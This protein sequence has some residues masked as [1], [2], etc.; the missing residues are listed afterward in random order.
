M[1]ERTK[2]SFREFLVNKAYDCAV[3]EEGEA[4]ARRYLRALDDQG[5]FTDA[6]IEDILKEAFAKQKQTG[7]TTRAFWGLAPDDEFVFMTTE[8]VIAEVHAAHKAEDEED[9]FIL[10]PVVGGRHGIFASKSLHLIQGASASGKTTFA[11]QMLQAQAESRSFLE[12]TSLGPKSY[13]VV[14]QDRG[15]GELRRQLQNLG[16][17]EENRPPY[18]MVTADQM[19]ME[20]ARALREILEDRR[21]THGLPEVVFAEGLDMWI[22]DDAKNMKS[23]ANQARSVRAVAEDY[24]VC[25]IGTIGAPKMKPKEVYTSARDRGFG[26]TA[27]SRVADTVV[28]ITKNPETG[29]RTVSVLSRTDDDQVV[30]M[31]FDSGRLVVRQ[32]AI[33]VVINYGP[34]EPEPVPTVME[35]KR[36]HR[37]GTDRAREIQRQ[38]KAGPIVGEVVK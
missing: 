22:T 14:W 35:I 28:D 9:N 5:M 27:W 38:L 17:W 11:L 33:P 26:S 24:G 7:K 34:N 3:R 19:N 13:L 1:Y 20:A 2:D 6:K 21:K 23:V 10:G 37:C 32:P 30:E 29:I 31:V 36:K 18:V 8:E 16:M 25:I 12:R 4:H 15:E